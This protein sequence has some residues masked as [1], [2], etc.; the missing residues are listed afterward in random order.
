[1]GTH[2]K[3]SLQTKEHSVIANNFLKKYNL[4]VKNPQDF[5]INRFFSVGIADPY[6]DD[7][8][9]IIGSRD[10]GEDFLPAPDKVEDF[11][12]PDSRYVEGRSPY[13]IYIPNKE[14]M[15]KMMRA[16][17]TVKEPTDLWNFVPY[18]IL[19]K[20]KMFLMKKMI[21]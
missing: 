9:N 21:T 11:V 20:M 10:D 19:F 5:N 6:P 1:M 16:C 8:L 12:Y 15:F 3:I 2:Q 17:I 13:C 18:E 14:I 7:D 4:I